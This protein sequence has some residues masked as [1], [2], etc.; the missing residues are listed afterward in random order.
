MKAAAA[1]NL[2]LR[3]PWV[4]AYLLS[5]RVAVCPLL[6]QERPFKAWTGKPRNHKCG[7]HKTSQIQKEE[8]SATYYVALPFVRTADGSAPVRLRNAE[9]SPRP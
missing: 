8:V 4:A 3:R 9:A 2:P 6:V 7:R 5:L 1:I